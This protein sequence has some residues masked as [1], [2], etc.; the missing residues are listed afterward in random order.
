MRFESVNNSAT[1]WLNG[2]RIGTHTGAFLPFELALPPADLNAPASTGSSCASATPT[3]SPTCRRR[4]DRAS[5][6]R[7]RLVE[8]RRHPARGLPAPRAGDRLRAACRSP[9]P[10]LRDLRREHRLL[11]RAPQLRLERRARRAADELRGHDRRGA[12]VGGRSRPASSATYTARSADRVAGAVVADPP[13]LYQVTL[14]ASA[15]P[16][17]PG[18]LRPSPTMRSRAGSARSPS[19]PVRLYLNFQPLT[20][21]ASG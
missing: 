2:H 14:D 17:G 8:L 4:I 12:G 9:A 5:A 21:A 11:G 10:R 6:R 20:F 15:G 19:R 1:I 16:V 18:A 3:R 7:R 13:H